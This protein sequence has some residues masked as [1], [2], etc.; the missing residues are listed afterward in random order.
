VNFAEI[1]NALVSSIILAGLYVLVGLSWVLLFRATQIMNFATGQ[2]V[3]LGACL[4]YSFTV[5]LHLPF[6]VSLLFALLIVAAIGAS[7]HRFFIRR[8]AGNEGF[9]APVVLTLGVSTVLSQI[10]NL[11]YGA[12]SLAIALPITQKN[13]NLSSNIAVTSNDL[14]T[15]VVGVVVMFIAQLLI[16]RSRWGIQMRAAAESTVLASQSGINVDRVFMGG[17]AG[18]AVVVAIVGI[19]YG[20][21]TIVTPTLA[22]IGI[23]GLAV[24]IVGGFDSIVGLIPAALIVA[25]AENLSVVFFGESVRDAAVMIVILI[26]L[27]VRPQGLLG[28]KAVVRV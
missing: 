21:S 17:W 12:G 16:R 5:S 26:V 24:A 9:F 3:L 7:I 1:P 8:M 23:R 22:D 2:F 27:A 25:L 6:I 19:T 10:V 15:L 4:Y 28:T 20:A 13:F 18:A 11:S 14:V